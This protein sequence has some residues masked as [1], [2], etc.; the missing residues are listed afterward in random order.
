MHFINKIYSYL[1]LLHLCVHPSIPTL[2]H[3]E[4]GEERFKTQSWCMILRKQTLRPLGTCSCLKLELCIPLLIVFFGSASSWFTCAIKY[5]SVQNIHK[6]IIF[7]FLVILYIF[8]KLHI[9]VCSYLNFCEKQV[10]NT[11]LKNRIALKTKKDAKVKGDYPFSN[12]SI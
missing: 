5:F 2:L 3:V 8:K 1:D 11:K 4:E 12:D 9:F 7:V 6:N 10:L